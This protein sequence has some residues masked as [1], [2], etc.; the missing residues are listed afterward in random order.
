MIVP[1]LPLAAEANNALDVLLKGLDTVVAQAVAEAG[2]KAG[3]GGVLG[4][5]LGCGQRMLPFRVNISALW[6]QA[7]NSSVPFHAQPAGKARIPTGWGRPQRR[8][9]QHSQ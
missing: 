7:V 2:D 9:L 5:A 1:F 4:G 3:H 8:K 6:G